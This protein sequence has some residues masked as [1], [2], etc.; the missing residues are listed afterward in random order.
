MKMKRCLVKLICMI[1]LLTNISGL[2]ENV[3]AGS[4]THP[5]VGEFMS[6]HI[7]NHLADFQIYG[8]TYYR[9]IPYDEPYRGLYVNQPDLINEKNATF[10]EAMK[11]MFACVNGEMPGY[12]PLISFEY[13]GYAK[14][15]ADVLDMLTEEEKIKA[16]GILNGLYGK[17]G[18]EQLNSIPGF[19]TVDISNMVSQYQDYYVRIGGKKY[20]YRVLMFFFEEEDWY[21]YYN[22]RYHFIQVDDAWKLIRINKEYSDEYSQRSQYI[23]GFEGL[24]PA[25]VA[26]TNSEALRDTSWGMSKADV[27]KI[28]NGR[29]DGDAIVLENEQIFRTPATITCSFVNDA[30]DSIT[31]TF[32]HQQLYYSVFVSLYIRYFDP[33]IIDENG[34]I[35]W[36]QND[37]DI[38]LTYDSDSP[39]L[40]FS[41]A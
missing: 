32:H 3:G 14:E 40:T 18:Y 8:F 27:Q 34:S 29:D 21:E 20:P 26:D 23:H 30:L 39:T 37:M 9:V 17:E 25:L 31:Y 24:D 5:E 28:F 11:S 41:P 35:T 15:Y 6:I 38:T 16:L 1:L 12:A 36:C 33:L 10:E 4:F 7:G 2:A 13:T 22:E 19:E